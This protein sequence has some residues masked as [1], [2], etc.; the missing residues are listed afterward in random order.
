METSA[1]TASNVDKAFITLVTNI[2][3]KKKSK[4]VNS[5]VGPTPKND[6]AIR[7]IPISYEPTIKITSFPRPDDEEHPV[8]KKRGC[9]ETS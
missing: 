5:P 8:P 3:Q 1:L 6:E 2:Y 4:S 9:C 7:T